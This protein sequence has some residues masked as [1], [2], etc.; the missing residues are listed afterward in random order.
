M[1][2]P[3][4]VFLVHSFA[5]CVWYFFFF[6]FFSLSL[7]DFPPSQAQ[8]KA[9]L[10]CVEMAR[11]R[12]SR[13]AAKLS[14]RVSALGKE[15]K[16]RKTKR[17]KKKEGGKKKDRLSGGVVPGPPFARQHNKNNQKIINA[18][19]PRIYLEARILVHQASSIREHT[20]VSDSMYICAF[21]PLAHAI[22]RVLV[23]CNNEISSCRDVR[24]RAPI[25]LTCQTGC[26]RVYLQLACTHKTF[27]RRRGSLVA[28]A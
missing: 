16:K 19:T 3:F 13:H 10:A 25:T 11:A 6:S 15:R 27:S 26:E 21:A 12:Q 7:F 5:V 18:F 22:V 8:T 17:G 4:F 23:S 20:V 28:C 1:S 24:C 9:W 14:D 2:T